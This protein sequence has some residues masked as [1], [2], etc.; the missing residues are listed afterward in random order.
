MPWKFRDSLFRLWIT[1]LLATVLASNL[2]AAQARPGQQPGEAKTSAQSSQTDV[3]K[4]E[5]GRPIEREIAGDESHLY[6]IALT[7]GEYLNAIVDQRGIDIAVK[8]I[9]PDGKQIFEFNS[10]SRKQGQETVTLVAEETGSHQLSVQTVNKKAGAGRYEIRAVQ[11]RASTEQERQLYEARKLYSESLR[12]SRT[13]QYDAALPVA[14]RALSIREKALGSYHP[15]VA[16]SINSFAEVYRSK[17]D[18]AKAEILH[19]RALAIREQVFGTDHPDVARSLNYLAQIFKAKGDYAKADSFHQRALAIR[20]KALGPD[21]PGVAASLNDLAILYYIKGDYAKA[22]SLYQRALDIREKVLGPDHPD[23]AAS[24]SNLGVLYWYE[25][26]YNTAAPLFERALAIRENA[27]GRDHP[28]IAYP[29]NNLASLYSDKGDYEKAEPLFK[30]ALAIG[31]KAL[32]PDHLDVA[33]PLNNLANL[34]REKGEYASAEPLLKRALAIREKALGPDNPDVAYS[35]Y[36]LASLYQQKGDYV[37]AEPLHQRALAIR[38]KALGPDHPDVAQSLNSL[39]ELYYYKGNHTAAEPAYLRALAI[40]EK[41]LGS[42]HYGVAQLLNNLARL[43]TDKRNYAKAVEYLLRAVKVSERNLTLNIATGSERQKLLYLATLTEQTNQAILMHVQ[44]AP[45][46]LS[47]RSLAVNTVLQ[48]KGRTLDAM[49]DIVAAVRRRANPADRESIRQLTDARSRLSKLVLGGPGNTKLAE[50][51]TEIKK[52]EERVDELEAIISHDSAEFRAQ[53]QT[54][55]LQAVQA[56]IPNNAALV[57]FVSYRARDSRVKEIDKDYGDTRYVAYVLHN[58]GEPGWVELGDAKRINDKI[59]ALRKALRNPESKDVIQLARA[60][61]RKVMQPVRRLLGETRQVLLSPDGLLN[62]IPFAA[63]ID[64]RNTYLISRYSFSYLSSGRDLLRLQAKTESKQAA[65]VIAD[66]DFAGD[67]SPCSDRKLKVSSGTLDFS[68]ILFC[69][70]TGTSDE[71]QALRTLMPNATVLTK[72]QATEAAVTQSAGPKILHIA[73]HGFFLEDIVISLTAAS[74]G[75]LLGST[76]SGATMKV[77]NPLLRSG[78]ALAGANLHKSG[79]DDGVLTA[80]EASGLD[81][82]GT[83]LVVLSACDTGVGEVK[84]GDGVYGLRRALVLAG[85]ESQVMSLW[86]VNDI[87]TRDLMIDYY[88]RLLSGQ[89][90]GEALR[91]VQLEMLASKNRQH[92]YYWASFIQSGEWANLDGKR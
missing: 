31:E 79:D 67:M 64:E 86:A 77:E 27:V 41:A 8:I 1:S 55:T 75:L 37:K 85:S 13:G 44:H 58:Q 14:E 47:A 15:D 92:P 33:T 5:A 49:T 63:L 51:Q 40:L 16:E 11:L 12:L 90:R 17:G 74:R 21:H 78:L 76:Q 4:L 6:E 50:Y 68:H 38:E 52:L 22:E 88:K 46:N 3:R 32:G 19:W 24:L 66:P 34:Y 65:M 82:W 45:H 83:K 72:D 56:A 28:L 20:E 9:G 80:L 69:P 91:Q 2:A 42:E 10:E 70:L 62:L 61:D 23:V 26:D 54:V 57:E 29:L 30:R 59:D 35:I 84:N 53:T 39:S 89:G 18:Y 87:A 60:V 73:T 25:G 81:L 43:S 36:T 7:A 71:A 48:R